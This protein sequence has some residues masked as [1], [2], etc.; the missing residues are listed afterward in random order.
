MTNNKAI[1]SIPKGRVRCP[2][3]GIPQPGSRPLVLNTEQVRGALAGVD[4]TDCAVI[5]TERVGGYGNTGNG[6]GHKNG[7]HTR[8]LEVTFTHGRRGHGRTVF[9]DLGPCD[10]SIHV[11]AERQRERIARNGNGETARAKKVAV[12]VR[13]LEKEKKQLYLHVPK[14]PLLCE[15]RVLKARLGIFGNRS[16][17]GIRKS[18]RESN[19]RGSP[20]SS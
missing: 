4:V 15:S 10:L 11:W 5:D 9:Y 14:H 19:W 3:M 18:R 12:M 2:W 8:A 1:I 17:D 13:R 20:D 6:W 7:Q 16:C